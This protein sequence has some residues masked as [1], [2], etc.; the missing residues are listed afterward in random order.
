MYTNLPISIFSPVAISTSDWRQTLFRDYSRLQPRHA[1][2]QADPKAMEPKEAAW[3]ILGISLGIFRKL[4]GQSYV[5]E[6]D[7]TFRSTLHAVDWLDAGLSGCS[8]QPSLISSINT[9]DPI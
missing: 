8:I 9:I 2:T 5:G 4:I 1:W 3:P 6:I 7:K